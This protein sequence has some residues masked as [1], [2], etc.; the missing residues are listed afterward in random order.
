[1]WVITLIR[2]NCGVRLARLGLG[3]GVRTTLG[4]T[5]KGIRVSVDLSSSMACVC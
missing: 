1:M 2:D 5:E 3:L 4:Q